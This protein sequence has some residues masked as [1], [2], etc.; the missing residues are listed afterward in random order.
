[1]VGK[2]ILEFYPLDLDYFVDEQKGTIVRIFGITKEGKK[3]VALD[4]SFDPHFYAI[5]DKDSDLDRMEKAIS[6]IKLRKDDRLV[7][8]LDVKKVRLNYRGVPSK[9]LKITGRTKQDLFDIKD[10]IKQ[11]PDYDG[12]AELDISVDKSYLIS[13]KINPLAKTRLAGETLD[14][15]RYRVDYVINLTEISEV[16][17]ITD[18]DFTVLAFDIETYNPIGTPRA[19]V[20]PIIAISFMDNK[21]HKKVITWKRFENPEKYIE[22]VDSEMDLLERFVEVLKDAKPDFLIT[23]NGDLFDYPYIRERMNK[24]KIRMD[25]GLD[26]S[27]VKTIKKGIGTVS[28]IAGVVSVDLYTF[29]KSILGPTL[30]TEVYS[31]NEIAK[32]LLGDQKVEGVHWENMHHLWDSGGDGVRQIAKYCMQDSE[33]TLQLFNKVYPTLFEL[34]KLIGQTA[35]NVSRMTYGQCVEWY[36]IKN[37]KMFKE[38]APKRPGGHSVSSRIVKTYT[39]A[40][41]HEPKPGLYDNIVVYDFASLYPSIIVSHNVCPTTFKCQ[42]CG[43]DLHTTPEIDGKTYSFCKEHPGFIPRIIE[44]LVSRRLRIKEIIKTLDKKDPSYQ[45]LS[46]RSYA[47][48]TVANSMYGYLGFARSRWYCLEC[49]ASIT[50]WGR[51]YIKSVIERVKTANF[52]VIYSDTDSIMFSLGSQ[53]EETSKK[54]FSKIN[55][56]LPGIM[57]IDFQGFY[58]RGIFV[59]KKIDVEKGAKKKYALAE[60]NGDIVVK[61][62]E[63]V[64]RDW[65][66]VAKDTQMKVL[67]AVL[68]EGSKEKALNIIDG[69]IKKLKSGNVPVEQVVIYTQLTRKIDSYESIGPHVAAAMKAEKKGYKFEPG[70][71]IK[72]VITKG[73]GSISDRAVI[74]SEFEGS[75]NIYDPDY[76]IDNQVLPAVEKIFEVLGYSK[77][78]LKGKLQTKLEGFFK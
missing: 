7:S 47:L 42:M 23:Y 48:K 31:L 62:F 24:Y 20:D 1:M 38:L 49:A 18:A 19:N 10:V 57:K 58:K 37:S 29:I 41:V 64:R 12:H 17:Q 25:L 74:L 51:H 77:D 59:T 2:T 4:S 50:A 75:E 76:Y 40:Y 21:G 54:L 43:K 9:V 56:E 16:E 30:K 52:E 45:V 3:V 70:H 53:S 33:L 5:F 13:K 66:K 68:L 11:I 36:L 60:E 71:M 34:T 61:G 14:D 28:K 8:P 39:G 78:E 32:E 69:T 72:Y 73:A 26:H 55:Q 6:S 15:K 63:L 27:D 46:A 22:F 35:F 67:Q 44:D 65:S